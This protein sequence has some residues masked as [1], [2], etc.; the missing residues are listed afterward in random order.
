MQSSGA[1][2]DQG[3]SRGGGANIRFCQNSQK[4]HEIERIGSREG[5]IPRT[6]LDPPLQW[7]IHYPWV[8]QLML[9]AHLHQASA[10]MLRPLCDDASDSVLIEINGDA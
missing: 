7:G 6:P 4:L 9:R 8:V 5:H 10:S 2:T 3:F 1:M